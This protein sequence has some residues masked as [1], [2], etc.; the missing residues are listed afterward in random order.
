[1]ALSNTL[2][3]DPHA[4]AAT[5]LTTITSGLSVVREPRVVRERFEE[6]LRALLGARSVTVCAGRSRP[7]ERPDVVSVDVPGGPWSTPAR[8]EAVFGA[9]QNVEGWQRETLTL[10]AQV[11]ALIVRIDDPMQ[12][13][14]ARR[15][16]GAAPLIGSS[17]AIRAVR[18]RIERVAAT[19]FTTLIEGESR[20]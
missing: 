7:S 14:Q 17:Q 18:E 1:M 9:R 8:L 20:R 5:L 2:P 4:A 3:E 19:D 16:D 11:A 12:W 15:D 10:A 13:G 6:E